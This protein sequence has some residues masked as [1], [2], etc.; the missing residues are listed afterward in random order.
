MLWNVIRCGYD[1]LLESEILK[2]CA[3]HTKIFYPKTILSWNL[4]NEIYRFYVLN[5]IFK[6]DFV[7]FSFVFFDFE[8]VIIK[9]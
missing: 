2:D 5:N 8:G 7:Y 3:K 6:A 1:R 9:H 4:T